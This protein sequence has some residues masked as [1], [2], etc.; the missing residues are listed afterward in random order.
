MSNIKS[1]P[2]YTSIQCVS[3]VRSK[4]RTSKTNRP[5]GSMSKYCSKYIQKYIYIQIY[6]KDKPPCRR[7]EQLLFQIY[8][9]IYIHPN[10]SQRQ[11]TLQEAWAITVPNGQ[12]IA[13]FRIAPV[14]WIAFESPLRSQSERAQTENSRSANDCNFESCCSIIG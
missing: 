4:K 2:I 6:P 14:P 1:H 12:L 3:L 11:T 8:P 13:W 9:K 7:H 5:A 10:I